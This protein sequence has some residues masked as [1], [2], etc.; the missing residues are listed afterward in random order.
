MLG[1][2]GGEVGHAEEWAGKVFGVHSHEVGRHKP[3]PAQTDFLTQSSLLI[4]TDYLTWAC[5]FIAKS[6]LTFS[7]GP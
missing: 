1:L 4:L 5:Q 3:I 6:P 2:L 7:S